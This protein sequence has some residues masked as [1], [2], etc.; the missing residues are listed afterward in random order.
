VHIAAQVPIE[1]PPKPT[2]SKLSRFLQHAESNLGIANATVYEAA[3]ERKGYG[4]DILHLVK[5]EALA[6]AGLPPG[7]VIRMKAGCVAWWSSSD[8]KRKRDASPDDDRRPPT[9]PNKKVC[10]EKRYKD[11]SG[12]TTFWGPVLKPGVQWNAEWD[13]YYYCGVRRDM[14]PVPPGFCVIEEE[15]DHQEISEALVFPVGSCKKILYLE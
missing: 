8:V 7:D 2:P 1:S 14:V 15:D 4:P 5:D 9:P 3:L 11:G 12:G 13:M 6:E 10:Y